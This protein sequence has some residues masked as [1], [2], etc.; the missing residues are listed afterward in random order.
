MVIVVFSF[1]VEMALAG[2][3]ALSSPSRGADMAVIAAARTI[4]LVRSL[5]F[6]FPLLSPMGKLYDKSAHFVNPPLTRG[7]DL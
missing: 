3:K 2:R 7:G 4:P 5:F 1:G 6:M